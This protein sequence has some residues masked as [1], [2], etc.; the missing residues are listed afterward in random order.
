MTIFQILRHRNPV[1]DLPLIPTKCLLLLASSA[2]TTAQ[3]NGMEHM[4]FIMHIIW[5]TQNTSVT[6]ICLKITLHYNCMCWHPN[7]VQN[8]DRIRIVAFVAYET[9]PLLKSINAGRPCMARHGSLIVHAIFHFIWDRN[10]KSSKMQQL[11]HSTCD[12]INCAENINLFICSM[13]LQWL[14]DA[15]KA[16]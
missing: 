7:L 15:G 9:K 4:P 10:V 12:L 8:W 6:M 2:F 1:T 14:F 16:M 13:N 11:L 3:K 5:M